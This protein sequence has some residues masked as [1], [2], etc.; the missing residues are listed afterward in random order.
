M[1]ALR[2]RREWVWALKRD[3]PHL[4]FSLN[5]QVE[6]CHAAAHALAAPVPGSQA[7]PGPG[8]AGARIEGVMIGRAAYSAPWACLADADVAVWG[9]PANAATCR[10]EARLRLSASQACGSQEVQTRRTLSIIEALTQCIVLLWWSFAG[11][12][13][14]CCMRWRLP[15]SSDTGEGRAAFNLPS[16]ARLHIRDRKT[17]M[18]YVPMRYAAY[19]AYCRMRQESN[20][21][22][23]VRAIVPAG[24]AI[25][26]DRGAC[27]LTRLV[28]GRCWSAMRRTAMR[29]WAAGARAGT[30]APC[31]A[32]A[33][34]PSRCWACS[35]ASPAGAGSAW[36][37]RTA[38]ARSLPPCPRCCRHAANLVCGSPD[39]RG[40]VGAL[41]SM[42]LKHGLLERP[43]PL[44]AAALSLVR[45]KGVRMG[46]V[47]F[48][49]TESPECYPLSPPSKK[50][51]L[52]LWGACELC[53]RAEIPVVV[54]RRRCM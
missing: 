12:D 4:A 7:E 47:A 50:P 8:T 44:C 5:G 37:W 33:R 18:L 2:R 35:T 9:A 40:A 26:G 53:A 39:W 19:W 24:P 51:Q 10:R 49:E 31:P 41:G 43:G 17:T 46:L 3:F 25:S 54:P 42:V 11:L 36:R 48:L 23:G 45:L 27:T 15:S 22:P 20:P 32:C 29:C 14:A 6:G 13:C 30:A 38:C 1:Q 52:V 16:L 34:W 21:E 28:G